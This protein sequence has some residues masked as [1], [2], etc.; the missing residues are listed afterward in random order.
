MAS[1]LLSDGSIYGPFIAAFNSGEI[2]VRIR[3]K[4]LKG[5]VTAPMT[6]VSIDGLFKVPDAGVVTVVAVVLVAVVVVAVVVTVLVLLAA[7]FAMVGDPALGDP[8]VVCGVVVLH[9][10]SSIASSSVPAF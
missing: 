10:H 7:E 6:L 8:A 4:S 1:Q 5:E 3:L 2:S 9:A